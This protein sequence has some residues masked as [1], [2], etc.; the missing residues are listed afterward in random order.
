MIRSSKIE[1]DNRSWL[2]IHSQDCHTVDLW[3]SRPVE[4][5]M[6]RNRLACTT[7]ATY[8]RDADDLVI[9]VRINEIRK[10][11]DTRLNYQ[12]ITEPDEH[13]MCI[14]MNYIVRID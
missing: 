3:F 5:L 12:H 10:V 9:I 13:T 8:S 7:I 6:T 1:K 11:T 2:E 14:Y 4:R